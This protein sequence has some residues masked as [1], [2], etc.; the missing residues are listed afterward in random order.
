MKEREFDSES[1]GE[2]DK[3]E[4]DGKF[5]KKEDNAGKSVPNESEDEVSE[6]SE[7]KEQTYDSGEER[8]VEI[9]SLK[10]CTTKTS[11][12]ASVKSKP[13]KITS[14]KKGTPV[15]SP[16][17][18]P[19]TKRPRDEF[20]KLGVE[21]IN[22][23]GSED[24]M[25][26]HSESTDRGSD[27]RDESEEEKPVS[28]VKSK[29]RQ[30]PAAKKETPLSSPKKTPTSQPSKVNNNSDK[31]PAVF[32]RKKKT[33]DTSSK[34]SSTTSNSKENETKEKS[35]KWPFYTLII[36]IIFFICDKV[37]GHLPINI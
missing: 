31:G 13:K 9:R 10:P 3:S 25:A 11:A 12:K 28:P 29:S 18:Q 14:E 34:K 6:H 22:K 17:K 33:Q 24:E 30:V 26:E 21:E 36:S 8:E 5:K 37:V 20:E 4:A 15:I 27:S 7:S 1:D 35:G 2:F 19:T 16:N 23:D 32:S